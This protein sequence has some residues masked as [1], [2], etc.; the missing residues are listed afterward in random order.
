[1][2][3]GFNCRHRA[4]FT[5]HKGI[6]E[7]RH[8]SQLGL[9]AGLLAFGSGCCCY[10]GDYSGYGGYGYNSYPQT[11]Y[12][13]VVPGGDGTGAATYNGIPYNAGMPGYGVPGQPG[14][15]MPAPMNPYANTVGPGMA[16]PWVIQPTPAANTSTGN[17]ASIEQPVGTNGAPLAPPVPPAP[18]AQ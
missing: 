15:G 18:P 5:A 11:Y 10:C 4:P 3:H 7:M 16:T 1:M 14:Y 13:N 2:T 9:L 12:G 6:S 17:G 8:L